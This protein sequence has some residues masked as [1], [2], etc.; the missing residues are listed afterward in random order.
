MAPPFTITLEPRPT[1]VPVALRYGLGLRPYSAPMLCAHTLRPYSAPMLCALALRPCPAPMLC[2]PML[3]ALALRPCSAPLLCAFALRPCSVPETT[4]STRILNS[5]FLF[6]PCTA[7]LDNFFLQILHHKDQYP[8][9]DL[10]AGSSAPDWIHPDDAKKI[11]KLA[12]ETHVGA[13]AVVRAHHR[14]RDEYIVVVDEAMALSPLTMMMTDIIL[15]G[16]RNAFNKV[17]GKLKQRRGD[18]AAKFSLLPA[19]CLSSTSAATRDCRPHF[20]FFSTKVGP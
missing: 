7:Q 6:P 9:I 16:R 20:R 13:H 3:C 17:F 5:S 4:R 12:C 8:S 2:A 18:C 15:R 19:T 11:Y 1:Y 14:P 10:E